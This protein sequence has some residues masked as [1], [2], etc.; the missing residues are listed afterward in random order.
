MEVD[1][2]EAL[3]HIPDYDDKDG[4]AIPTGDNPNPASDDDQDDQDDSKR[5]RN[6]STSS[7]IKG[8]LES[9]N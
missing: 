8:L 5:M 2:F 1:D 9:S 3:D 7:G 4:F 6:D